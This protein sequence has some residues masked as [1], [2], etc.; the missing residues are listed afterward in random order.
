MHYNLTVHFRPQLAVFLGPITMIPIILF[1]GFF[2]NLS[3]VPVWLSWLSYL[4]YARYSF[5]G[6]MLAVYGFDREDMH[7]SVAFCHYRSPKKFLKVGT[8][9]RC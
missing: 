7:C 3:T 2:V 1:S 9:P 8:I 6:L 4:S 5:E